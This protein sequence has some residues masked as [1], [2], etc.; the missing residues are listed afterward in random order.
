M[1]AIPETLSAPTSLRRTPRQRMAAIVLNH[2]TTEET[3]RA[4][5][6][7]L[8]STRPPDHVVV[9]DN[10]A[11]D[12]CRAHFTQPQSNPE[13]RSANPEPRTPNPEP[14]TPNP[15]LTYLHTGSNLGFSGGM[16]IGVRAALTA[17]ADLVLLAN[18]DIEVSADCLGRM[19]SVL[20][21]K[22]EAGIAGPLVLLREA[23][24][25]VASAG[26][27]YNQRSGRMREMGSGM[28]MSESLAGSRIVDAVSGCLMMV[29][30]DVFDAVGLL[31]DRFFFGFEDLDFCL[32]ARAAGFA[33]ILVGDA[34][35]FHE[36]GRS[37]G[38]H[39]S[40]RWYFGARNHLL[41]ASRPVAGERTGARAVRLSWVMALNVAHALTADAGCLPGRL[42]ATFRGMRDHCTGRYGPDPVA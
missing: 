29:K 4:V 22:P 15:E 6:S 13:P 26:I 14:R 10:D 21:D 33:T 7:L 38:R 19:E 20:N 28:T 16:N 2:R 5:R 11:A 41:L 34:T 18:S 23:P 27:R 35:A 9:I 39:S 32:R 25:R 37:I 42:A 8:A 36:G 12:E 40:R 1:A 17:G 31:D 3:V 24:G 30:R